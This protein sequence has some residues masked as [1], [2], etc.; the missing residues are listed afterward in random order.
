MFPHTHTQVKEAMIRD[1]IAVVEPA[2]F[3][4]DALVNVLGRRV[5][6]A[7]RN[8]LPST[9]AEPT[10]SPGVHFAPFRGGPHPG[11]DGSGARCALSCSCQRSFAPSQPG[12]GASLQ[13]FAAKQSSV[14]L[15][16][17]H[18]STLRNSNP[19]YVGEGVYTKRSPKS[20][21]S[22]AASHLIQR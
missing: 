13:K 18:Q 7:S 6:T 16:S 5:R 22:S 14:L 12:R 2:A 9:L 3:D 21:P 11:V 15:N 19:E 10:R 8:R 1:T 20:S 17:P 4:R